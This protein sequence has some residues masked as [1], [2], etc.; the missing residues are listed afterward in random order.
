[1]AGTSGTGRT[2]LLNLGN[3]CYLNAVMQ[4]LA[5]L[6]T[7][8]RALLEAPDNKTELV[9]ATR[10]CYATC[11]PARTASTSWVGLLGLR[12]RDSISEA[13]YDSC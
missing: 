4:S 10:S 3:T 2:G 6:P 1:M 11:G 8:R 9:S 13:A 5:Q 12:G 7:L